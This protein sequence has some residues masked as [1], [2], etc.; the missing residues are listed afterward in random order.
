MKLFTIPVTGGELVGVKLAEKRKVKGYYLPV[1]VE[2]SKRSFVT[3]RELYKLS[4]INNEIYE[5][6]KII[7]TLSEV[8]E[9]MAKKWGFVQTKDYTSYEI[10]WRKI[11]DEFESTTMNEQS[12]IL[13]IFVKKN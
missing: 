5:R 13:L 2:K 12:N 1:D 7:G 6:Y 10:L 9:E 3:Q 4:I 8:T 11:A